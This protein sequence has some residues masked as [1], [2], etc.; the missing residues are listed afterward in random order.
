[1][2]FLLETWNPSLHEDRPRSMN[3][4][5]LSDVYA[6]STFLLRQ[7]LDEPQSLVISAR[8]KRRLIADSNAQH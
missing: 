8:A 2:L 1:M 3:L 4:S 5:V 7:A 6:T